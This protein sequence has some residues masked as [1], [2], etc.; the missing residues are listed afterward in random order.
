MLTSASGGKQDD[1]SKYLLGLFV[2]CAAFAVGF[3]AAGLVRR[4]ENT[5]KWRQAQPQIRPEASPE[6]SSFAP[7]VNE[8]DLLPQTLSPYD[9]EHFINAHPQAN[10]AKLWQR[11]GIHR[12]NFAKD[13]P[14]ETKP[15][16][17]LVSCMGCQADSIE[18]DLD[19]EPGAEVLL[20]IQDVLS[21]S[22]RYLVFK[23]KSDAWKLLGHID[24]DFGRYRMPQH[25]VLLS[26]NK[27]W[28]VIQ[29]Q[30]GSGSGVSLYFDRVFLVEHDA[31]KEVMHYTSEGHQSSFTYEPIREFYGRIVNCI[32]RDG[33]AQIEIEFGV[34]YIGEEY[35]DPPQKFVLFSKRQKAFFSGQPGHRQLSR[36]RINSI[37]SQEEID[38]VFNVNSLTN[39]EFLKYNFA[40]LSQVALGKDSNQRKWLMKFLAMSGG[41]VFSKRLNLLLATD[42]R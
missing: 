26:N 17:F 16:H 24:H 38:A 6:S 41:S 4:T 32:I 21:E 15:D 2:A 36:D 34:N 40:E 27:T 29:A 9:I 22:C 31:L 23:W 1:V 30:G 20:R 37:L 10:L 13:W 14:S 18:I 25:K 7:L 33:V 28:L 11:L 19:E 42:R 8:N 35:P 39:E 12:L 3:G 5:L